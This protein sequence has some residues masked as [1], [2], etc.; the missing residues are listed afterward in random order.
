M[1][2]SILINPGLVKLLML[3]VTRLVDDWSNILVIDLIQAN[4]FINQT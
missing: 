3:K 2:D 1:F 4:D